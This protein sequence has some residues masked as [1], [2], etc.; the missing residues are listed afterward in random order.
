MVLGMGPQ[1][2][3]I[4]LVLSMHSIVLLFIKKKERGSEQLTS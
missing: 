4:N 1:C 3:A 2:T